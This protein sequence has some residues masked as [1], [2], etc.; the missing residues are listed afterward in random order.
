MKYK[1]NCPNCQDLIFYKSEGRLKRFEKKKSLC[2]K[3]ILKNSNNKNKGFNLFRN[4]PVC[5][6]QIH[7][8][9][10]NGFN[11]AEK[12]NSKCRNC[13]FTDERKKLYSEKFS[14]EKNPF[15][16]KKQTQ[17][18]KIAAQKRRGT[19]IHTEES[20]RKISEHNTLYPPMKGKNFYSLWVEKYGQQ[21]ADIRMA[22][23]KEKQ[24]A[25]SSGE[26][27]NMFG[28]PSPVGSGNGY[29]GW[30]NGHFFRSL[31][32]L[33][34]IINYLERFNFKFQSLERK[35]FKIKYFDE[36][37]KTDRNYF[38]DFLVNEKFF[39]EIKPKKLWDT[40]LNKRKFSAAKDFCDK[41]NLI[42]KLIDPKINSSLIIKLFE[43]KKI[44]FIDRYLTKFLIWKN[45]LHS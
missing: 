21:E 35:N 24:R 38:G 8:I 7:Y 45:Q 31:K 22:R 30:Y 1:R 2:K 33:M 32:E 27:N 19:P 29:S 39:V 17:K 23:Y 37:S 10:K 26:K 11:T 4:C 18:Q 40:P 12:N 42:F 41:N 5:Q 28:K 14:G 43:E 6:S 3:C 36:F 25:N 44:K 15:F 13:V 34:F 20:K 16:G 9:S